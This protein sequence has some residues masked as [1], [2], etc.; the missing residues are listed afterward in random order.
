MKGRF[1]IVAVVVVVIALAVALVVSRRSGARGNSELSGTIEAYEVQV[2]SK[3]TARVLDVRCEEGQVVKAGDT[4]LVLDQSDYRNAALAADAQLRAAQ[5]NLSAVRSRAALADSSLARLRRLFSAGNLTRQEMDKTESDAK[6][7]ND[8]LAAARTTVDAAQAQAN[9]ALARLCDCSVTAPVSG[10][11]TTVAFRVG[12][13]VLAGSVPV[14]IIDLNQ[15]WLN[16]YLPER[17]LGK[18]RA[19]DS[20]RVR[21]DAY[22]KRD[23]RGVVSFIADKAEF[24]PKDI[25]TREERISQ[26]YRLKISLPNA[27]RVLKPG[28]PADAYLTLH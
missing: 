23:F 2:A 25:Q 6:A 28:M 9:I 7:A 4:L 8:A 21:I 20:C 12:E 19:G 16:V 26:V 10:T 3:V 1:P 5:A 11:V 24:T 15:T 13:T 22:P 18:V 14:T 27:D 17:L